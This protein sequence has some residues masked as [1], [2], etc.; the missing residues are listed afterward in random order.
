M[1]RMLPDI[2]V[3]YKHYPEETISGGWMRSLDLMIWI[4]KTFHLKKAWNAG[5]TG[6]SLTG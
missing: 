2:F 3:P 4:Q 6:S 1:Y 5:I